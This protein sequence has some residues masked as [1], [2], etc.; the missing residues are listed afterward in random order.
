MN[1]RPIAAASLLFT[2]FLTLY[3]AGFLVG[4]GPE[5]WKFGIF[6]IAVVSFSTSLVAFVFPDTFRTSS[7]LPTRRADSGPKVAISRIVPYIAEA[8]SLLLSEL[9]IVRPR[10]SRDGAAGSVS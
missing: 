9:P 1:T 10:V 6:M 5:Y 7:F 2:F 8:Q 4:G 3:L